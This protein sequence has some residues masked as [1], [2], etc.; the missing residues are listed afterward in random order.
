MR[1]CAAMGQ[2]PS[3]EELFDMIAEVDSDGSGEIGVSCASCHSPSHLCSISRQT[4]HLAA[5]SRLRY[6]QA[7]RAPH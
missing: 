1:V 5:W 6:V 4:W 2:D 3:D 7:S